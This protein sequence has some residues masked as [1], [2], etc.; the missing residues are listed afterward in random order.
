MDSAA[1]A[2]VGAGD[3]IFLVDDFGERDEGDRLPVPRARRGL[4]LQDSPAAGRT[5]ATA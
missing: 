4:K 2:T 5:E 3:D 1:W